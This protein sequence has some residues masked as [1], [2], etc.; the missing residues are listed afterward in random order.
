MTS[1]GV[2]VFGVMCKVT[3]WDKPTS[4]RNFPHPAR[5]RRQ[6]EIRPHQ[7]TARRL[8]GPRERVPEPVL[9]AHL[10]RGKAR[11][12]QVARE[13]DRRSALRVLVRRRV[14]ALVRGEML[15]KT[16]HRRGRDLVFE[17]ELACDF[18]FPHWRRLAPAL[19]LRALLEWRRV[20]SELHVRAAG[21]QEALDGGHRERFR[22][23]RGAQTPGERRAF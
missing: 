18:G 15:S 20:R 21:E 10:R 11:A 4:G 19:G 8:T 9:L 22:R 7:R 6:H 14:D 16:E 1:T 12:A 17:T 5:F 13:R 3:P 2:G 23:G